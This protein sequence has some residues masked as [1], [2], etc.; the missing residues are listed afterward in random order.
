MSIKIIVMN[1][2]AAKSTTNFK[3]MANFTSCKFEILQKLS[4]TANG[5]LIFVL[6]FQ[7]Q[8]GEL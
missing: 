4:T 5:F 6:Y 3:V 2:K 1:I 8:Q 7:F